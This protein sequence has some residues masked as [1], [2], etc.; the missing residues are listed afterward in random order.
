MIKKEIDFVMKDKQYNIEIWN[1]SNYC[2][3][4]YH[5]QGEKY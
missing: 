5:G 4:K 1:M 3:L 2:R